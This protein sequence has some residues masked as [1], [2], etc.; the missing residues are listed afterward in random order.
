MSDRSSGNGFDDDPY[1]AEHVRAVRGSGV[2]VAKVD[3]RNQLSTPVLLVG[4]GVL[5]LSIAISCYAV[6][7]ANQAEREAQ[8]AEREARV[9]LNHSEELKVVA[10]ENKVLIEVLGLKNVLKK[11][12]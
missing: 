9:A 5:I 10:D 12:Q 6:G 7:S 3:N 1:L 8:N 2:G 11:E 4:L